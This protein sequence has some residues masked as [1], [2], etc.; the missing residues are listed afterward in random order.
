M[1]SVLWGGENRYIKEGFLGREY[2]AGFRAGG[3]SG[4]AVS[5][6]DIKSVVLNCMRA[7][8]AASILTLP[9][10]CIEGFNK[11]YKALHTPNPIVGTVNSGK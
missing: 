10:Q 11:E 4:E 6:I 2:S 5:N 7:V 1:R 9:F 3:T 8:L